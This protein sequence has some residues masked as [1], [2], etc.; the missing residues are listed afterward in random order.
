MCAKNEARLRIESA[1]EEEE[2]EK[3]SIA[4]NGKLRDFVCGFVCAQLRSDAGF[5]FGLCLVHLKVAASLLSNIYFRF[6][7]ILTEK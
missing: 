7:A 3:S 4:N 6:Y 5:I 2:E 1:R